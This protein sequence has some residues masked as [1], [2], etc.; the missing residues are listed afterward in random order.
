MCE[1]SSLVELFKPIVP[2]ERFHPNFVNTLRPASA[3]VRK[4]LSKWACG[5]VDRDN[6][7]IKEFQTTYN[8]AFWELYLFA[9]CKELGIKVD[10]SF[11]SPDFVAA[12]H[13]I[14]IEAG[15]ASHSEND[16]PEWEK[17]FEEVI[18]RDVFGA[19]LESAIRMSNAF[20]SKSKAYTERYAKLPH[21]AGRSY[22]IAIAN[23]GTQD[24][25]LLGDVPMQHLLYDN[26]ELRHIRKPNGTPVPLDYSKMTIFLM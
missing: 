4:V 18:Q 15:I 20:S 1:G 5:F 6:R 21:M 13:P 25:N 14:A 19:Q 22:I 8:S 24:F 23:Y 17:R 16:V 12:E 26:F 9:V 11:E 7:F 10:F 3:S 2:P